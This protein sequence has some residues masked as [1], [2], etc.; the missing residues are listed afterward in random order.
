MKVSFLL[1]CDITYEKETVQRKAT[2]GQAQIKE[3]KVAYTYKE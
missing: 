3:A 1:C 2:Y